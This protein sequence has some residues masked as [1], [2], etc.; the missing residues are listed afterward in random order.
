M[1][2][3]VAIVAYPFMSNWP[4]TA[5]WLSNEERQVLADRIRQDGMLGRMD[6]LDTKAIKR[7]VLDWKI[8]VW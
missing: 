2:A 6:T 1:S 5:K 8:W 7:I 4:E 3:G